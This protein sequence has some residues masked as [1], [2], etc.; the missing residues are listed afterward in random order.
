MAP[1][2]GAPAD[3]KN[4]KIKR[5]PSVLIYVLRFGREVFAS[6]QEAPYIEGMSEEKRAFDIFKRIGFVS[7]DFK[8]KHYSIDR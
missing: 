6:A 1:L 4:R 5:W 8:Y 2:L 7:Q 3:R